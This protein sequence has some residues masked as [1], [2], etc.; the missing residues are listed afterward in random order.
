MG[1]PT[2]LAMLTLACAVAV[3]E[4]VWFR[5]I[6]MSVLRVAG[7][8]TAVIGSAVLSGLFHVANVAGGEDAAAAALQVAFAALFGVVAAQL[9]TR[10]GS[11]WPAIVWHAAWDFVNDIGGN[12]MSASALVG[13]GAA[14]AIMLVYAIALWPRV[15][16]AGAWRTA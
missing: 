11:L 15:N 1:V 3:N 8:R 16:G 7:V 10:T 14:C 5:G 6:V 9:V 12:A 2:A 4:D 13:I